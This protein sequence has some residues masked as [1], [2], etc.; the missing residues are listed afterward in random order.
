ML[1]KY[2]ENLWYSYLRF[3][4][5][6]CKLSVQYYENCTWEPKSLLTLTNVGQ[7][8]SSIN[9]PTSHIHYASINLQTSNVLTKFAGIKTT[10]KLYCLHK[11]LRRI[12]CRLLQSGFDLFIL[13]EASHSQYLFL[14]VFC[15]ASNSTA[16]TPIPYLI[17]MLYS[18]FYCRFF[19]RPGSFH[20]IN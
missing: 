16:S 15:L 8:V 5:T 13:L 6:L 17:I 18:Y 14:L 1:G 9:F 10:E 20:R 19:L 7:L 2:L 11:K 4:S 12:S 3:N